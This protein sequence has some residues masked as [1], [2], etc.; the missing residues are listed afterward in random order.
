MTRIARRLLLTSLVGASSLIGSG[1]SLFADS[2]R[3]VPRQHLPLLNGW[4][5]YRGELPGA[6]QPSF[7][8]QSWR[9]VDLPHDWSI[10]DLPPRE[11]DPVFSVLTLVPGKWRF[12]VG[13]EAGWKEKQ[14]DDSGWVEVQLPEPWS[15]HADGGSP[16]VVWYRREFTVPASAAGK[17]VMAE[18]GRINDEDQAYVDGEKAG[19]TQGAYWANPRIKPR[20]YLLRGNQASVGKHVIAVRVKGKGDGGIVA[21]VSRPSGPSPL[22]PGRSGGGMGAGYSVGGTGWYRQRFVLPALAA[23]SRVRVFF[24]GSYNETTVWLNGAEV[25]RNVYGYTPFVLDLTS[26][27]SPAGQSNILAVRVVNFGENSR[28]YSGSGLYRPVHL[29]ITPAVSVAPWGLAITTP[30]STAERAV[31]RAAVELEIGQSRPADCRV[32]LV[33]READGAIAAEG[34][35]A[36]SLDRSGTVQV[37]AT[38]TK[39]KFWSP[40]TP[41]LYKAEVEL[42]VNDQVHDRLSTLFGIRTLAWNAEQGFLLNGQSIELKGGCIHH[43]HGHLGAA[44]FPAAEQ[45][46][47]ARLKAAGYNA[48]RCAHN[49]PSAAFLDACDRLGMLVIDEAFDMWNKEKNPDDYHRHFNEWWQRDVD[50]MVRRDRNHPSVVIWS[51]GNEL[52]ER[53]EPLGAETAQRLADHIRGLDPTRPITAAFNNVR[54]QSDPFFAALDIAGYNYNPDKYEPD[55]NRHPKR[56]MMATESF[57][58][59]SFQYWVKAV[60]WPYVIGDFIWTAWDYRGE[61]GIGH[62]VQY[63]AENNAFLMPW[64]WN[65]AYC[66]DFDLCGFEKPQNFYREVLWGV[67]PIALLV[68][69]PSA[70][71]RASEPDRWG[72]W[73]ELPSWTWPGEEGRQMVVRVYGR[74]EEAE[75]LLNGQ[76][77]ARKPVGERLTTEFQ[78]AY[79][80]GVLTARLNPSGQDVVEARLETATAPAALRMR[81]EPG[82]LP[83]DRQSIA[84]VVIEAVDAQG[85]LVP[86]ADDQVRVRVSGAGELIAFGNG[87]PTDAGSV[88]DADQGLWRG[89]ALAIVRSNGRPG[90]VTCT[91]EARGLASARLVLQFK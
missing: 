66:G 10:E 72:W 71:G 26:N 52:G 58:R 88:K 86:V 13:D 34:S 62:T 69:G 35:A 5:F 9:K 27:L 67:R 78:V 73:D 49:P 82:D 53:F 4:R 79:Q 87:D 37:T 44:S 16:N 75:L 76:P 70:K 40:A 42:L 18:V 19:E 25:G 39:P 24:D 30:D 3:P 54:D 68:D 11:Q 90:S 6:E 22:D 29:E 1:A 57:P 17:T 31:V 36:G 21:G 56:V 89:K 77:V 23:G 20:V 46:R 8:D 85:R 55:H 28:W 41:A 2:A 80:P 81:L 65:N 74:G 47:V 61:S 51:I 59:D 60:R 63:P 43:D 33:I 64:P 14:I 91:A 45:R 7:N 32:R 38:V 84:F 12:K 83:A 48:I 15:R 50:A